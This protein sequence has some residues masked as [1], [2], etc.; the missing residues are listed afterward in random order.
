MQRLCLLPLLITEVILRC[1]LPNKDLCCLVHVKED[2]TMLAVPKK[3]ACVSQLL[4]VS[5]K[6]KGRT[7]K[8][9]EPSRQV[10]I[11]AFRVSHKGKCNAVS[12]L[13]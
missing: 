9:V 10:F 6:Q 8:M 12:V 3:Y 1:K 13:L 4:V 5:T 7:S 2:I 11:A